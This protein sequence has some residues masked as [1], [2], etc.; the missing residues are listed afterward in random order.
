MEFNPQ[1]Q[2]RSKV[3]KNALKA[4]VVG[5]LT[6]KY[7]VCAVR[8][9]CISGTGKEKI[10]LTRRMLENLLEQNPYVVCFFSCITALKDKKKKSKDKKFNKDDNETDSE[11]DD[12][13]HSDEVFCP[14]IA[15]WIVFDWPESGLA[16][17]E[18][19]ISKEILSAVLDIHSCKAIRSRG[20]NKNNFI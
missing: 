1:R 3:I 9:L 18:E 12:E 8:S 7:Q 16:A 5:T 19:Y 6:K 13:N 10:W 17:F 2:L 11:A 15:F 20:K 14:G 4:F